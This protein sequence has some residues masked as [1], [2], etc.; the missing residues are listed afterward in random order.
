M[1]GTHD[2]AAHRP[3]H[4]RLLGTTHV[5]ASLGRVVVRKP[6]ARELDMPKASKFRATESRTE[7][8]AVHVYLASKANVNVPGKV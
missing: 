3:S 2:N 6:E 1:R 4:V 7:D 8:A 5:D